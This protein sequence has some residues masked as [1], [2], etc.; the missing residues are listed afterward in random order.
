MSKIQSI[1]GM[2]KLFKIVN[3][4]L[5]NNDLEM[6]EGFA[7][8]NSVERMGVLKLWFEDNDTDDFEGVTLGIDN[9][10]FVGMADNLSDKDFLNA[11]V[12]ELIHVY[13]YQDKGSM[14]HGRDFK[15]WCDT[16]YEIF[17]LGHEA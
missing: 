17:M 11:F 14:G 7:L 3:S 5:F 8:L 6:P 12:H 1:A 9:A 10:V 15:K 16:A 13:Q 2:K 4:E